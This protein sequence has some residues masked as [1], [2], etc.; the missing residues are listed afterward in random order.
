[1]NITKV[2][3]DSIIK[4]AGNFISLDISINSTGWVKW[5]DGK[6]YLGVYHINSTDDMERK[7]EFKKFLYE[8]FGDSTYECCFVEDVFGGVNFKT[9]KSLL[10]LNTLVDELMYEKVIDVKEIIRESNKKWKRYLKEVCGYTAN[11]KGEN[12]KEAIVACLNNVDFNKKIIDSLLSK[13]IS[14]YSY[15]DV[16][17]AMGL[18]LGLIKRDI[19]DKKD[20][21]TNKSKVKFDIRKGYTIMQCFDDYDAYEQAHDISVRR[22]MEIKGVDLSEKAR[23]LV[24]NFKK[25]VEEVGDNYI[26]VV[27]VETNKLGVIALQHDFNLSTD[28]SY[29]VCYK[30]KR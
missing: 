13:E 8:L 6:L 23:D 11:I 3:Y 1:M 14:T 4:C 28:Y 22:C 20:G 2:T 10:Q 15:Q 9:V 19:I 12:D 25:L 30:N 17:D 27:K 5:L 24:F 26:F 7:F 21:K 16:Y 29:L 18:A